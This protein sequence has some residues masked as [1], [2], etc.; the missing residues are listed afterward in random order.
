MNRETEDDALIERYRQG[1]DDAFAA[2]FDRLH[3]R[4]TAFLHSLG[5]DYDAAEDTAQKT[6]MKAL[7]Q[8]DSY[9][10][11]GRFQPW[12]FQIAYRTHL[13]ERKTSWFRRRVAAVHEVNGA[14]PH[15]VVLEAVPDEGPSPRETADWA[16]RRESLIRA[17]DELNPAQ[18]QAV[19]LRLEGG[20]TYREIA[21]TMGC[22]LG[23]ALSRVREAT[24]R[25]Q[26]TLGVTA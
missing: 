12:M 17:L 6:W 23:T 4:L 15:G 13:D 8:L 11:G 22:P 1:D 26:K 21:E 25:L 20:L 5:V 9:R 19:L 24:E 14:T 2:L 10:G 16:M 18:R 7:K 3:P